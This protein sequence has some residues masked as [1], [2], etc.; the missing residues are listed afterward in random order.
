MSDLA[1][2]LIMQKCRPSAINKPMAADARPEDYFYTVVAC[3]LEPRGFSQGDATP[4][5]YRLMCAV[6]SDQLGGTNVLPFLELEF[7]DIE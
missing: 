1:E 5:G 3:W 2:N 7:S 6:V 4:I